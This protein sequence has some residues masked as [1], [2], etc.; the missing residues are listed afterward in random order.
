MICSYLS[1]SKEPI[2][3]SVSRKIIGK[4]ML[5]GGVSLINP[6]LTSLLKSNKVTAQGRTDGESSSCP[7]LDNEND[8]IL[9]NPS[10]NKFRW[11]TKLE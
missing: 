1:C 3:M 5:L 11:K 8:I 4:R 2:Y 6:T 9:Y 7:A 10:I